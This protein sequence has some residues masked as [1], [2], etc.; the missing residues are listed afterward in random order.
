MTSAVHRRAGLPAALPRALPPLVVLVT[1]AAAYVALRHE[2]AGVLAAAV[3]LLA[4]LAWL[5][6]TAALAA[7][8]PLGP[9][10]I[11]CT[12]NGFAAVAASVLV[13]LVAALRALTRS[14]PLRP[15]H[16]WIG[17]LAVSLI[18]SFRFSAFDSIRDPAAFSDLTGLLI[19][20]ALLAVALVAAPRPGMI[21]RTIALTGV[22]TAGYALAFGDQADG[23]LEAL[24]FNPNYLGGLLALPCVAAV[25]LLRLTRRPMWAAPA[26]VCLA[27]IAGTQSRGAFVSAAAGVAVVMVQGRRR[28]SLTLIATAGAALGLY[29][30]LGP[31]ERLA[32][33]GRR[34]ADLAY[35]TA[36]RGQVAEFAATVAAQHPIR[37]IGLGTFASYAASSPDFGIYMATHDDY[38]RL[39]AEAG[40]IA[41]VLF[42]LLLWRG[43][44]AGRSGGLAVLRAV[45]VAYAAGLFFA[46]PLANLIAST[47][48]WLSL[49][50]LLAAVPERRSR[51]NRHE[52]GRR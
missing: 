37:G 45:T 18:I 46:N 16:L 43:T 28:R 20:L 27:A 11:V 4:L 30:G 5:R 40:V 10:A 39:A 23:R 48:F 51:S 41:L 9:L 19:G 26:A 8:I 38:L 14:R 25:G 34:P 15:V 47:P 35:D 22:I 17:L 24:G 12:G 50:C 52:P 49:G 31:I 21:A 7:L 1:P 36:V 42:L 6:P 44:K 29:G 32:A 3:V 13:V 2:R 33:G